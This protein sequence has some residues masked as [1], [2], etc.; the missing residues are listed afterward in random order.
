MRP[1]P[2]HPAAP[3][4]IPTGAAQLPISGAQLSRLLSR[5]GESAPIPDGLLIAAQPL[6]V[7]RP[8]LRH[9]RPAHS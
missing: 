4:A 8:N 2:A 1:V 7:E 6:T 3:V 5:L 9:F